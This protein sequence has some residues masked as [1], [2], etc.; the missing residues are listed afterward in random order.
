[1]ALTVLP[2]PNIHYDCIEKLEHVSVSGIATRVFEL[3]SGMGLKVASSHE[4]CGDYIYSGHTMIMVMSYLAI[5]ECKSGI[6]V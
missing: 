5:K 2:K 3:L 4:Y 1:M 6:T